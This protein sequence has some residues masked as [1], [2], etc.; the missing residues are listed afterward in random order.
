MKSRQRPTSTDV[1]RRAGVSRAT[2]SFVLNDVEG[3][4]I[5][6][7]TADRVRRAADELGYV[8]FGAARALRRGRSD[9]ILCLSP[10][11]L[12]T[13]P[14]ETFKRDLA[15][16]LEEHGLTCLF[17]TTSGRPSF[18]ARLCQSL[19]PDAVLLF[20][21]FSEEEVAPL[22]R[23]G[24][25]LVSA[26]IHSVDG[27]DASTSLQ[28]DIGAAMAAHLLSRGSRRPAFLGS[29]DE[30][31]QPFDR[32][33]LRGVQYVA[34]RVLGRE[35]PSTSIDLEPEAAATALRELLEVEQVDGICCHNDFFA[36]AMLD[37]ARRLQVSVPD[38]LRLIGVDDT[39]PAR[40]ASPD[41]SS[42]RIDLASEATLVARRVLYALDP[43]REDTGYDEPLT[44]AHCEVIH[45]GSS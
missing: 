32:D 26:L 39:V 11:W 31:E 34:R 14:M 42:V 33:R 15:D 40:F 5:S 35:V 4:S 7:Q 1:A 38:D 41:L 20:S 18:S 29:V 6:P 17:A 44:G 8:P 19:S 25:P 21:T 43:T 13:E 12:P 16:V 28:F 45:R 10:A 24:V 9:V 3:E 22:R 30:R 27:L 36:L 23:L 2:V 37:A